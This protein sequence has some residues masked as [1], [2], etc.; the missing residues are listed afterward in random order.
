MKRGIG[1]LL[2]GVVAAIALGACSPPSGN[3][4]IGA[5]LARNGRGIEVV[6]VPCP[7]QKVT[8]VGPG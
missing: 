2:A 4:T 7:G 3:H 1:V 5:R 6:F 8:L